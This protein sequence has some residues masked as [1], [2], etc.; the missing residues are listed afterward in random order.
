MKLHLI[1]YSHTVYIKPRDKSISASLFGIFCLF[2][3]RAAVDFS[4]EVCCANSAYKPTLYYDWFW[5][6]LFVYIRAYMFVCFPSLP[7]DTIGNAE[8]VI[9]LKCT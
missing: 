7:I 6:V 4:D 1:K 8:G 9:F 5:R 3:R 2:F